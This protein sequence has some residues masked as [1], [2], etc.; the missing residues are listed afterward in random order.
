MQVLDKGSIEL[1]DRMGSDL[2]VV[3][4]ARVSFAK[5]SKIFDEKDEKLVKYLVNHGHRSPF[6]HCSLQFRIRAPISVHRQWERHRIGTAMNSESTRYVEVH[7]EFYLPSVMRAQS[8]SNKQ[9]SSGALTGEYRVTKSLGV[10]TNGPIVE[11]FFPGVDAQSYAKMR[12][13]DACRQS[14]NAYR[15]MV[16][17]GVAKEQAR[18]V[19]P[20]CTYVSFIWTASLA[21][22]A[23]FIKLRDEAHAQME[24]RAYAVAM[25]QLALEKFPVALTA[26]L[27][28]R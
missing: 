7:D 22:V 25:K 16:K 26:L 1:I 6:Y 11:T 12:Y 8:T 23:H 27:E 15:E 2:S 10:S 13:E 20:L 5:E 24:I 3:N 21:A 28:V 18:D 4:T 9:G 17:M 19:L 14:F